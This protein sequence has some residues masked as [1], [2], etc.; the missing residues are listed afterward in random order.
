MRKTLDTRQK[1]LL[2]LCAAFLLYITRYAVFGFSYY[3]VLDDHIQYYW[4]ANV[5]DVVSEVFL[6]IGTISTRPL[7]G[8]FDV[9]VWTPLFGIRGAVLA[10]SAAVSVLG[11]YFLK[12]TFENMDIHAGA[13]FYLVLLF[14]PIGFETQYWL[15]ASSRVMTG[16]FFASLSMVIFSSYAKRGGAW[17]FCLFAVMQ[18]ASYCFYEQVTIFSFLLCTAYFYRTRQKWAAYAVP[19][20]NGLIIA[21]YYLLFKSVGALSGRTQLVSGAEA[22]S[23]FTYMFKQIREIA[24][25]GLFELNANG[26]VRG[27]G[28]L[29]KN[30]VFFAAVTA[31]AAVFAGLCFYDG[32]KRA[33]RDVF[34]VLFGAVCAVL[35]MA[36]MFVTKDASL[37]YRTI[38]VPLIGLCVIAEYIAARIK[39]NYAAVRC[40]VF[41]MAFIFSVSCVSEMN[42]YKNV[43]QIDEKICTGIA[44]ALDDEVISGKRECYVIGARR[45]YI[46]A[47]AEHNEHIINV[48][49]SDWA[50]TGA[51]RHSLGGYA[52]R[53]VPVE[54]DT[55][56]DKNAQILKINEDYTVSVVRK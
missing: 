6:K 2:L 53:I 13:L 43:S 29:I 26:L 41:V 19:V 3:P 34:A 4:Y 55:I 17:R 10:V 49:S 46:N 35:P 39:I 48:T 25:Q 51:V 24:W 40:I 30:P 32:K 44:S 28:V 23:H 14:M 11:I 37:P 52:G 31:L 9:Y 5:S 38:Y 50:L 20:I 22:V 18:L 15:S 12:R 27:M 7:A 21:V 56:G 36:L 1:E 16:I 33:K 54:N 45:T 42:D 47:N 8:I